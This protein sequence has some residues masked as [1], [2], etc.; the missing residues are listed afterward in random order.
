MADKNSTAVAN[1]VAVPPVMNSPVYNGILR[2][3]YRSMTLDAIHLDTD[4]LRI[5]PVHSS[6]IHVAHRYAH[7][8][9]DTGSSTDFNFGLYLG[10]GGALLDVNCLAAATTAGTATDSG[11]DLFPTGLA[12]P[13]YEPHE[14]MWS[15]SG[16][17]PSAENKWLDVAVTV[18]TDDTDTAGQL[19]FGL[20]YIDPAS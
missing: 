20:W 14:S 6:W 2:F 5:L 17:D 9:L 1:M 10:Y 12:V 18:D 19:Y 3:T 13:I 8:D 4:V 7:A 15:L 11:H 16:S